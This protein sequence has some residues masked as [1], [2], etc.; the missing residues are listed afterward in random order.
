M[1]DIIEDYDTD[2]VRQSLRKY[3][4]HPGPLV[5]STKQL[6][7]KKLNRIVRDESELKNS[8][9]TTKIT[10]GTHFN[11]RTCIKLGSETIT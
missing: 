4:C 2:F 1:S 8:N 6:Y 7:V 10:T 11:S 9:S 3:G 5:P